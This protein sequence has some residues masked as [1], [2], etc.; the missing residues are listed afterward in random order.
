MLAHDRFL[1]QWDDGFRGRRRNSG[2]PQNRSIN[3]IWWLIA[4][5]V[6][7]SS[8]AAA[9]KLRCCAAASKARNPASGGR[10]LICWTSVNL[11]HPTDEKL[12]FAF[13]TTMPEDPA[14]DRIIPRR[15]AR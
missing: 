11:F 6:T 7:V 3:R 1:V 8:L 4:V 9:L 10:F 5:G 12:D 14:I 13:T 15:G 2:R